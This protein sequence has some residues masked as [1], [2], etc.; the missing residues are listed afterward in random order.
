MGYYIQTGQ[1][2]RKAAYIIENF[3]AREIEQPTSLFDV[4]AT[5][6][7]ICVVGNP[8]FEAAAFAYKESELAEFSIP[9]GRPR[10]WL[11]M[12]KDKA[13]ELTGYKE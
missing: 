11:A 9:D 1:S 12:D 13:C 7:I 6:A 4:L 3:G 5:E 10:T 8:G 2:H